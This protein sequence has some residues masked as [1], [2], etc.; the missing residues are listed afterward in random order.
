MNNG[1]MRFA[2]TQDA[3]QSFLVQYEKWRTRWE[4]HVGAQSGVLHIGK[5]TNFGFAVDTRTQTGRHT[6]YVNI[7]WAQS[8]SM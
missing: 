2:S 1:E 8:F 4:E 6:S 3:V 5:A 7:Q